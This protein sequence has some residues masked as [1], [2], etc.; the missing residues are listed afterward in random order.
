MYVKI[1][2][3]RHNLQYRTPQ[4][5]FTDVCLVVLKL[6]TEEDE[7]YIIKSVIAFFCFENF[8]IEHI[9]HFAV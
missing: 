2:E 4:I 5:K 1:F 8:L 3:T 7:I 6:I 9:T